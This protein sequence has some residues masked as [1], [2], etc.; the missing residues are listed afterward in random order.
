[1]KQDYLLELDGKLAGR[2]F[3]F[4]GGSVTS[5]VATT[6]YD[7]KK[8]VVGYTFEDITI[9]CGTG[10][11]KLFFD[12]L[13]SL[14]TGGKNI[15]RGAILKVDAAQKEV[16]RLEFA[17]PI[18]KSIVMPALKKGGSENATISITFSPEWITFPDRAKKKRDLGVYVGS[19]PKS[20]TV[21]S[22]GF[23]I[24]GLEADSAA[25]SEVSSISVG[26]AIATSL[27]S[28][29]RHAAGTSYSDVEIAVPDAHSKGL[30]S[31]FNES[32]KLGTSSERN[33]TVEYFA[34][35]SRTAYYTIKFSGLMITKIDAAPGGTPKAPAGKIRARFSVDYMTLRAGGAAIK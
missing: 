28:G 12:W 4:S 11:S 34:P 21:G 2:F 5:E 13:E 25:I 30:L 29:D 10:M 19:I 8:H 18:I 3:S 16:F 14:Y 23:R 6:L 26:Q 24:S 22:F 33:G 32:I 31:W 9:H 7:G 15:G 17:Y 20:W 1:M 27:D 35:H